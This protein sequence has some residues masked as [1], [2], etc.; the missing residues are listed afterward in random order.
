MHEKLRQID[1]ILFPGVSFSIIKQDDAWLFNCSWGYMAP[2]K[3]VLWIRI[4]SGELQL[5]YHINENREIYHEQQSHR[6]AFRAIPGHLL[7]D[8]SLIGYN[9]NRGYGYR[10]F[11]TVKVQSGYEFTSPILSLGKYWVNAL[12]FMCLYNIFGI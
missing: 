8:H 7:H 10:Y 1:P 6:G 11:C 2:E 12:H 3:E 4:D 5:L 9:L